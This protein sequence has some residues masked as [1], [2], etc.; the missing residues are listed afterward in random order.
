M[1]I[2]IDYREHDLYEQLYTLI[3]ASVNP[4]YSTIEKDNLELGDIVFRRENNEV[5]MIIER[6][7]LKD[8]ISSIKDGRYEEQCYRL[9]H[10]S[11]LPNHHKMYLIEGSQH[12]L[13]SAMEKKIVMSSLVSL[14]YFKGFSIMRTVDVKDT[15]NFIL[16]Y[17]EKMDR[18]LMKA[19]IPHYYAIDKPTKELVNT[20]T[21]STSSTPSTPST[22]STQSTP[23][24]STDYVNVV[25]SQ[26]KQ[27]IN[28]E[29]IGH[30]MLCQ[31]PGIS[32]NIAKAILQ[33]YEDFPSFLRKIQA[34]STLL[35]NL[36]ITSNGKTR[37]I[38]KTIIENLKVYLVTPKTVSE[39]TTKSTTI[40]TTISTTNTQA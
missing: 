13:H 18:D 36:T 14:N 32:S 5:M 1:K 19:R 24:S 29:N 12:S 15:A 16:Q 38:S 11:D 25:K 28:A 7:T 31:I 26:K 30:I 2:I 21:T 40:S 17:S 20:S 27:N 9:T 35:D 10:A 34:D 23:I 6:K 39:S 37:K 8:L 33:N 4:P 22:P 3:H